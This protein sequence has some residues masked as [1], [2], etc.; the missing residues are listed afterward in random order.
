MIHLGIDLGGTNIKAAVLDSSPRV[1]AT[2]ACPTRAADG[3]D[4]VL[5]R[6]AA[7]GRAACA[8]F[9]HES[10]ATTRGVPSPCSTTAHLMFVPP[11][12][13]PRCSV[14][15]RPPRYVRSLTSFRSRD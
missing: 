2:D 8:P 10:E 15:G 9:G 11:R 7:L 14:M 3:P 5:E 12:S 6:V 4:A 13:S 1:L